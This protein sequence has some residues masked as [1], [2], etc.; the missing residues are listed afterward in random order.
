M[1]VW[2]EGR[3]LTL[4]ARP[5][6]LGVEVLDESAPA[7]LLA[8][9]EGDALIERMRG[10]PFVSLPGS[11]R[12]VRAIAQTSSRSAPER[13]NTHASSRTVLPVVT[14]SSRIATWRT[15]NGAA[16]A[17]APVTLRRR[18]LRSSPA[19]SAVSR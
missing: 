7:A 3:T 18:A 14:T 1:T 11:R 5:G 6:P 16:T 13:R 12:E 10:E 8:R 4:T 15:C 17:N 2:R 19:C 9:R